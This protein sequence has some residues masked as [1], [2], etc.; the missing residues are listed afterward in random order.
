M[1]DEG[2]DPEISAHHPV[3]SAGLNSVLEA[4]LL[5]DAIFTGWNYI[6]FNRNQEKSEPLLTAQV[7]VGALEATKTQP[8]QAHLSYSTFGRDFI[9]AIHKAEKLR[10][11]S[12]EEFEVRVLEVPELYSISLWLHGKHNLFLPLPPGPKEL[13]PFVLTAEKRFLDIL[14]DVAEQQS[15][16]LP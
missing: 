15:P 10:A 13:K 16:M 8:H 1:L 9:K 6:V 7:P 3:Y 5:K 11:K 12:E 2:V 4:T 14:R